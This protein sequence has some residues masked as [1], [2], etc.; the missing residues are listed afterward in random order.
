MKITS[1][2]R[3]EQRAMKF[4][5]KGA[6]SWK[7]SGGGASALS[8]AWGGRETHHRAGGGGV[9]IAQGV[10]RRPPVV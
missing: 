7:L 9:E 4:Q 8:S 2:I 6:T 1:V 3:D 5:G 10:C